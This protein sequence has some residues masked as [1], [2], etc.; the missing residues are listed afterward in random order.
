[1]NQDS[2]Q[3]RRK[4][5]LSNLKDPNSFSNL[6][7]ISLSEDSQLEKS[8]SKCKNKKQSFKLENCLDTILK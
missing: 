5:A 2:N 1:M 4:E 8:D 7:G 3:I 6:M